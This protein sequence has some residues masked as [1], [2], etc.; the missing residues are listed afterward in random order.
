MIL[1]LAH[2]AHKPVL[3]LLDSLAPQLKLAHVDSAAHYAAMVCAS[4]FC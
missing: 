1:S 3:K 4:C 2:P